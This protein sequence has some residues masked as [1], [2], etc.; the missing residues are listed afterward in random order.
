M[1]IMAQSK[2]QVAA[3]ENAGITVAVSDAQDIS[4]IYDAISMLGIITGKNDNAEELVSK[5]KDEIQD[6]SD[7]AMKLKSDEPGTVYFEVSPLEWGLWAAG[8]GT[9]MDEAAKL[10]GLENA[11]SDIGP[12]AEISQEQVIERDPDYIVSVAMYTGEGPL[13]DEEIMARAGWQNISA[14]AEKN[15]FS[16]NSDEFTRPGPRLVDGIRSLFEFV[17]ESSQD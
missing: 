7:Q 14:V 12:W 3:L 10:V 16:A 5:M 11:F 9:F 2:E 8:P 13:P 1:S 4:G 6:I 17:Y 15:V